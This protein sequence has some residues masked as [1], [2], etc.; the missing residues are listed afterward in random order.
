[1]KIDYH[2]HTKYCNHAWGEM[3]EFV[4]RAITLGFDEIGFSDHFPWMIQDKEKLAMNYDEVPIYINR[5][6][7]LQE[8]YQQIKI[9]LGAEM[10]Y[11]PE[12]IDIM[13]EYCDK[14]D[15]DYIIGSVHHIGRW[16][17]DQEEQ[18]SLFNKYNT[19]SIYEKYFH[20][21]GEL[22]ISGLIDI[23]GHFDLIKKFGFRPKEKYDYLIDAICKKL[24][25]KDIVVEINASGLDRPCQEQYPSKEIL[26]KLLEYNI[27]VT[28]GSDS[29]KPEEVG[30]Y[31]N[32]IMTLLKEIG[33]THI[34]SFEKRKRILHKID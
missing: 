7:E 21:L 9:R 2:I 3:E 30:R 27:K 33:F 5:V 6:K 8:K 4:E 29:H 32:D 17:F 26:R 19:L 25:E 18:M 11:V 13:K 10:D 1:M 28:F 24:S 16:G 31:Y 15:Y 22:I 20:L 12:R 14:Y 23:I 34:C